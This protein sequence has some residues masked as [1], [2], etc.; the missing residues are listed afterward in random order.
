[1]NRFLA[2][3]RQNM[4]LNVLR[5]KGSSNNIKQNHLKSRMEGQKEGDNI[6]KASNIRLENLLYRCQRLSTWSAKPGNCCIYF[7]F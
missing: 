7:R 5:S 6:F 4:F 2:N 3:G 1:M